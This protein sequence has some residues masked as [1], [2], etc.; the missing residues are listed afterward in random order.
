MID[1]ASLAQSLMDNEAFQEAL[2]KIKA[3]ALEALSTIDADDK[4]GILKLQATVSV[5]ND[6]R[7][8][9][10]AFIRQGK[11]PRATGIA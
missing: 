9:L 2:D 10:E 4:N 3:G 5:V 6:I 8:D 11:P 7:D 1:Y